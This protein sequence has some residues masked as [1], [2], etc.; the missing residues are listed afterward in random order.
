MI[1][2]VDLFATFKWWAVLSIL[3][4]AALPLTRYLLRRLPD[5]GYAFSKMVGLLIVSYI[6]WLLGSLGLLGNNLGSIFLAF[7]ALLALSGLAARQSRKEEDDNESF[8][9][10]LGRHW[11]YVLTA[12]LVFLHVFAFWVMVRAQNPMI[13]ATEKPMDFAFL[14]SVGR[15][16]SF[17]P[18]DPWLSGFAISY[19]YFGYLMT[20]VITR[21]AMVP[22]FIGFNLA[23]AWLAAGTALGAE[24]QPLQESRQHYQSRARTRHAKNNRRGR[25]H[26]Q[27]HGGVSGQCPREAP[28]SFR[29][30]AAH[31]VGAG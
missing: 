30:H 20:S 19:Y 28:G 26:A 12:E 11:G 18:L 13:A 2:P 3:G 23:V 4:L 22:E 6:F 17:P 9:S 7:I 8:R 10:W 16:Q 24:R 15:S 14:N 1:S 29:C 27:P 25:H 31:V 5:M 21:L